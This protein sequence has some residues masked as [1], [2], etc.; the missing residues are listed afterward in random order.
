MSLNGELPPV[1][2]PVNPTE[3]CSDVT[4]QPTIDPLH[5]NQEVQLEQINEG[6]MIENKLVIP[7]EMERYL[8]QVAAILD[9]DNQ[10]TELSSPPDPKLETKTETFNQDCNTGATNNNDTNANNSKC[11]NNNGGSNNNNINVNENATRT[12]KDNTTNNSNDDNVKE[13]HNIQQVFTDFNS[14]DMNDQNVK[15]LNTNTTTT[16]TTNNN[17]AQQIVINPAAQHSDPSDDKS[18][19]SQATTNIN[20][21][22]G[23]Y[24]NYGNNQCITQHGHDHYPPSHYHHHHHG[25]YCSQNQGNHYHNY[26]TQ[27]QNQQGRAPDRNGYNF[28]NYRCHLNN[29]TKPVQTNQ[30]CS[31]TPIPGQNYQQDFNSSL[32]H[33]H[34]SS[35]YPSC[36]NHLCYAHDHC[37]NCVN[38]CQQTP[39]YPQ[40]G[41]NQIHNCNTGHQVMNNSH[42]VH[43][44]VPYNSQIQQNQT[45][46]G[47]YSR[48]GCNNGNNHEVKTNCVQHHR[49]KM[50]RSCHYQNN[51]VGVVG[52]GVTPGTLNKD[53]EKNIYKNFNGENYDNEIQCTDI[54]QSE[55]RMPRDAYERTLEYVQQCQIWSNEVSSSTHPTSNMVVNDLTSSLNSLMQENRFFQM[56]N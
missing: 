42:T 54:S 5:P 51:G 25:S 34:Q 13:V 53:S 46:N 33:P 55:V 45:I 24:S 52:G 56:I 18:T 20:Q 41:N 38:V 23:N 16:T 12:V 3:P 21:Q 28:N 49:N 31:Q 30:V 48:C 4:Q 19:V 40:C 2:P 6:E 50:C 39:N 36:Q 22:N 11:I 32:Q 10:I 17:Q 14:N 44:T 9:T 29:G 43:Q 26:Q 1:L 27:L 7:D 8:S 35:F 37:T 15:K 47:Q